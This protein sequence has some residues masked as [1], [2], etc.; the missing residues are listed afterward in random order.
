L[1]ENSISGAGSAIKD[2]QLTTDSIKSKSDK[3]YGMSVSRYIDSTIQGGTSGYYFARNA[4]FRQNRNS[5]NGR[6]NMDKFRDFL[7]FN[8][9]TNFANL[10]WQSIRI[11]NRII[12]GLVGRWMNRSEKIQIDATDPLSVNQKEDQYKEIE[13]LLYNRKHLEQLQ[14][15]SGVQMIP[16]DVYIPADREELNFLVAAKVLRLPEEIMYETGI[17]DVASANGCFDVLKDKMLHD[18]ADVGFVGAYTWMDDEGV[19]HIEDVR[20]ENAIYSYSEYNDFRDTTWRGR[21]KSIKISDLR[22]RYGK[23]FNPE[24]PNALSEEQLFEIAATAKEYQL[25]DKLTWNLSYN[26][27]YMRPYDEWNVEMLEFELRTVDN[28][29]YTLVN[30]K[31]STFIKRGRPIKKSANEEIKEDSRVNIYRSVYLRQ[32]KILLEWGLKKNMIRPQDPKEIGNAE[33]S[34]SFYMYQNYEMRNV[35][36]PEKIEEPADQMILARL[37]IQQLVATMIPSGSATNIDALQEIDLGLASGVSTPTELEKIYRQ[38]GRL[39]YRGRDSEGNQIPVPIIELA[40]SGFL[41]QMDGLIKLYQ[42]HYQV[43]K[44]ELGE[45]PAL[46]TSALQPRVTEGNVNTAQEVA[47]NATDYMYDAYK[48]VMEDIAKKVACLLKDS[49]EYGS[50]AYSAMLGKDEVKGR[51]FG[52]KI[53]MLPN[54]QQI[55]RFE[56]VLNNAINTNK[57]L[58]KFINAFQLMRVANEDVKLAEQLFYQ[59]QK[60]MLLYEEKMAQQ[61]SEMNAKAQQDSIAIKSQMDSQAKQMEIQMKT[62]LETALSKDRQK[63]IILTGIFGIYQKGVPMPAELTAL[64]QEIIQNVGLP[65]FAENIANQQAIQ[66][67][68]EAQQQQ[69][70]EQQQ[71]GEQPMEG[72]EQQAQQQ[73]QQVAA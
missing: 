61:N 36:I 63:E 59:G 33:F 21:V 53:R 62:E 35:A 43:L 5:A 3:T 31:K 38:T 46:M 69:S 34:Y 51:I 4:R 56:A 70:Q 8:G 57:D 58:I 6:I 26:I 7:E 68:A 60:K 39:Y 2:F 72:Q 19:I 28:E 11:V 27:M 37:K 67:A 25:T 29:A 47:E 18:S 42:F 52:T 44:D 14:Q 10:N 12:S 13:F 17:N 22:K 1:D 23:E 15:E 32:Q 20:P 41:S 49:V 65:L 45:D 50:T 54:A 71:G 66:E 48:Y 30:T 16:Q 40:N 55:A 24:N 64:S 9:K 73:S